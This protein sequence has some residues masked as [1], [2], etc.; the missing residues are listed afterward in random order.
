MDEH[1]PEPWFLVAHPGDNWTIQ[2]RNAALMG[3]QSMVGTCIAQGYG[4]S[5]EA[6]ARRIVA[7]VNA[8]RGIGTEFL[9]TMSTRFFVDL[10]DL[11]HKTIKD[12]PEV[13]EPPAPLSPGRGP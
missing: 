6:D 7:C 2:G 10:L 4:G 12:N 5:R 11:I 3:E 9:E 13:L 8:C 1:S